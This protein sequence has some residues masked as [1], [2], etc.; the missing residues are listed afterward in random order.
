[1]DKQHIESSELDIVDLGAA[2]VETKGGILGPPEGFAQLDPAG[3]SEDQG[4][5]TCARANGPRAL[6]LGEGP[7]SPCHIVFQTGSRP[8]WWRTRRSFSTP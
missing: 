6:L 4:Q 3:L 2:S 1:M 5:A 8:A 7:S